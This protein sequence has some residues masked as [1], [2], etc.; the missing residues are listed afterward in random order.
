MQMMGALG[1][2]GAAGVDGMSIM[3]QAVG[4]AMR[5]ESPQAFL[6]RLS[7]QHPA[8]KKVNFEDLMGSAKQLAQEKGMDIDELT[9]SVD[10]AVSPML[11]NK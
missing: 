7:N 2:G 4:A 11:P 5:G 6:K 10:N 8:F 9:K 1:S 3:M